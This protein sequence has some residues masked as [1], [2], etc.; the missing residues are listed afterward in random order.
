MKKQVKESLDLHFKIEDMTNS[1]KF[2]ECNIDLN[3]KSRLTSLSHICSNINKLLK[4]L[5]ER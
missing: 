3:D 4:E 1:L 2:I 5:N